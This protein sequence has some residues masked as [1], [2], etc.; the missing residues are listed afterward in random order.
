MWLRFFK[1]WLVWAAVGALH[2]LSQYS[3][4]VKYDL[5]SDFN[6]T[7]AAMWTFSYSLWTSISLILLR[8]MKLFSFPIIYREMTFLFTVG[9]IGWLSFYFSID[10]VITSLMSHGSL[11]A[12][13][14]NFTNTSVSSIFF[15]AILYVLTFAICLGL[16]LAEKTK[17]AQIANAKLRQKQ[18]ESALL[19]SENKMQLMQLQL[20]PHFLFNCMSA[21]SGLARTGERDILV[22]AVAT[23][24]SL[25][26]FTTENATNKLIT[27][28]EEIAFVHQYVALQKLRFEDRFVI[29]V[30]QG[31]LDSDVM[32]PPFTLQILIENTFRHAV[33]VTTK[34]VNI[35][36]SIMQRKENIHLHV[37]NT[38][39]HISP[40]TQST[41][42]GL[43][44]LKAR[45][46][47]LYADNFTFKV[48]GDK[49]DFDVYLTL[50]T[51]VT[52]Q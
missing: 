16:V 40:E 14:T 25:L 15:Y 9:L 30:E 19:I 13:S 12:W 8:F 4:I 39:S 49:S 42:I 33:E 20:S 11:A 7:D 45:I 29:N 2:A 43:D 1:I 6:F 36:V 28:D 51:S 34:Q 26:R 31:E 10:A 21:L 22:E 24:G 46:K 32:C 48:T 37:S 23:I 27:L 50:P 35:T 5:Q 3:D 17:Q 44:N 38:H 52:P 18:I 47:H 41:G